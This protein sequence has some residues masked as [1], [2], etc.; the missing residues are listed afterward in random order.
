M[1]HSKYPVAVKTLTCWTHQDWRCW[2]LEK[3]TS[4]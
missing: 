1:I 4:Q 2:R 3:I